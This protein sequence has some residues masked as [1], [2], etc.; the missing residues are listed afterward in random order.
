MFAN[1]SVVAVGIPVHSLTG[2]LFITSVG[3][4]V[5]FIISVFI[6]TLL[7]VHTPKLIISFKYNNYIG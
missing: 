5:L 7:N 1:T 6:L 2:A 3:G 4:V